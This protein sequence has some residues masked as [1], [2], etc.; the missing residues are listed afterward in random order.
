MKLDTNYGRGQFRVQSH[1]ELMSTI[2]IIIIP[3]RGTLFLNPHAMSS[4]LQNRRIALTSI[5]CWPSGL[6]ATW[7]H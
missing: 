5:A 6:L 3:N 2:I 1:P 4:H 7:A